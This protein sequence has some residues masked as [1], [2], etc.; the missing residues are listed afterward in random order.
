MG[1]ILSSDHK[2]LIGYKAG[3]TFETA[4]K[5]ANLINEKRPEP[6]EDFVDVV[7]GWLKTLSKGGQS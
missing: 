1:G 2:I 6:K 7:H 3:M 5:V 4:E